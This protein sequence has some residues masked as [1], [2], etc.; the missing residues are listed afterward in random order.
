ML[1]K[2]SKCSLGAIVV[3]VEVGWGLVFEYFCAVLQ[4]A[5][6][7]EDSGGGE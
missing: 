1:L 4:V 3:A 6:G 7:R 5:G 2:K